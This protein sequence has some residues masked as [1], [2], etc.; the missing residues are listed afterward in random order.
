M[1]E[2]MKKMSDQMASV[3]E[4]K[5]PSAIDESKCEWLPTKVDFRKSGEKAAVRG[6]TLSA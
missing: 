2:Q 5:Q 4:K 1:R 6:Y 3:D